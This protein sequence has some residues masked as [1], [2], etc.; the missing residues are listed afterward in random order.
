MSHALFAVRPCKHGLGGF[1]CKSF[2]EGDLICMEE[3]LVRWKP[4]QGGACNAQTDRASNLDGLTSALA[5]LS[6]SALRDYHSLSSLSPE[7]IESISEPHDEMAAMSIWMQNSFRIGGPAHNTGGAG[8]E[9]AV[10]FKLSRL[11]HCCRPNAEHSWDAAS[12]KQH[13]RAL[14]KIQ[15]GEQ[16]LLSYIGDARSVLQLPRDERQT[17]LLRAFGFTCMCSRCERGDETDDRQEVMA[18]IASQR[19]AASDSLW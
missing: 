18:N 12:G 1:A 13:V 2:E 19:E 14:R 16:I 5:A 9:Q 4:N 11:N 17:M 10:F 8:E 15:Y 7:V 6:P 3:P